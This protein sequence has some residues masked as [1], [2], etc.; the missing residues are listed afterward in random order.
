LTNAQIIF[1]KIMPHAL[2]MWAITIVNARKTT[3]EAIVTISISVKL[4]IHVL[5]M[6]RVFALISRLKA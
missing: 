4:K 3:T 2:D 6:V 5:K 1:A